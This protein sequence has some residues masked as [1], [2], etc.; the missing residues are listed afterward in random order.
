MSPSTAAPAPTSTAAIL[1]LVFGILAWVG[2]PLLGSV[3]AVISGYMAR[4]EIRNSGGTIQGDG[5]AV[6][7]LI[8]GWVQLALIL[9]V[10]LL[11][12]FVFGGLAAFLVFAG[13][14]G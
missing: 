8:L 9:L 6:A 14:A 1:S 7:G 2:L 10:L 5:L 3:I 12:V 11:V 13:A 4:T